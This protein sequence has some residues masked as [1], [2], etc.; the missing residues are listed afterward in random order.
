MDRQDRDVPS[1]EVGKSRLPNVLLYIHTGKESVS[2]CL[3]STAVPA[4]A[5]LCVDPV[6]K[7]FHCFERQIPRHCFLL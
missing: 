6:S 1:W 4:T 2:T 3:L 7:F 5:C